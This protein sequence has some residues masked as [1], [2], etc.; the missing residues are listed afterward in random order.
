[1]SANKGQQTPFTSNS[2]LNTYLF[3]ASQVLNRA[4]TATLVKVV[5]V[6]NSGGLVAAGSVDVHPLVNQLDGQNNAIP[7]GTIHR[8]P[9]FRLQ[10]GS[11]AIILDPQVGDIGIAVFA[12]HDI[13]SVVATKAQANPGSKRRFD[14]ADGLYLGGFL[15]GVP[16]QYFQFNASGISVVSNTKITLQAPD[17]EIIGPVNQSGGDVIVATDVKAAG[18][19]LKTHVHSGVTS[20][21]SNTGAPV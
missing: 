3:I 16:T 18:V 6:T 15:N 5:S 8:L 13:S 12:D 14:M 20:G 17:I 2:D 10:G 19:S 4:N 7:H 9:Y 1:M 11:N 21:V